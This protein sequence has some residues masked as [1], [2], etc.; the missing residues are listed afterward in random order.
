MATPEPARAKNSI[1]HPLNSG[2]VTWQ[3]D[4]HFQGVDKNLRQEVNTTSKRKFLVYYNGSEDIFK[5]IN[6]AVKSQNIT[7][8]VTRQDL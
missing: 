8:H 1:L 5:K 6:H 4:D 7:H 3:S 2:A